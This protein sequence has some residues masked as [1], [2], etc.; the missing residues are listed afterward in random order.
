VLDVP[1]ERF[2]QLGVVLVV[3]VYLVICAV[4]SEADGTGC[5]AA[6]DVVNEQS[7]LF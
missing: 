4:Q 1:R 2:A 6:I 3:E 7:G 5:L